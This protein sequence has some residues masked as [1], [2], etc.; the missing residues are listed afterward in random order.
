MRWAPIQ[1]G[2]LGSTIRTSNKSTPPYLLKL[3]SIN[4]QLMSSVEKFTPLSSA[5]LDVPIRGVA[6]TM[7]SVA[8]A[9]LAQGAWQLFLVQGLLILRTTSSQT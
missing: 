8:E 2:N 4:S 3:S 7:D 9:T 5:A 1:M 6:T